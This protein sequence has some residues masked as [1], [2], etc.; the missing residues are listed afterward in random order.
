M[1]TEKAIVY[2]YTFTIHTCTSSYYRYTE[3]VCFFNNI[4]MA[5]TTPVESQFKFKAWMGILA[6]VVIL[7]GWLIGGYND[8]AQTRENVTT[9]WSQVEVTYQRRFD[10][11]PNLV[12]SVQG[13]MQQEKDVFGALAEARTRYSGATTQTDKA[14]AIDGYNEAIGRLL[15]VMENYPVLKSNEN[16]QNLMTQLEGTE[17]RISVERNRFNDTAN[18]YNKKIIVFP[19]NLLANIFGFQRYETFNAA[20][21]AENAPKVQFNS[22]K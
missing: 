2:H 16:V 7:G 4:C 11:I 15:V 12:S 1:A 6:I 22:A 21:G 13:S 9:A 14:Q 3:S 17:N 18:G 10:L 20:T 5:E 8:M 19:S